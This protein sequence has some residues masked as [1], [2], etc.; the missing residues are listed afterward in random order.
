[1]R[2]LTP[3]GTQLTNFLVKRAATAPDFN[4]FF[5]G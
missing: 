3:V 5:I 1:M 4:E 2:E